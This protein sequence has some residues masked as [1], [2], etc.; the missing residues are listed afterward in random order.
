MSPVVTTPLVKTVPTGMLE[1]VI[2][3]LF[4]V[5]KMEAKFKRLVSKSGFNIAPKRN[6]LPRALF[7]LETN[8]PACAYELFIVLNAAFSLTLT[9]IKSSASTIKP[10]L[11][12]TPI[13]VF[14][15]IKVVLFP[16]PMLY[17]NGELFETVPLASVAPLLVIMKL[18]LVVVGV[19]MYKYWS[20]APMLLEQLN[21]GI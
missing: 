10:L 21:G 7:P 18:T 3:V 9:Y 19:E 14:G 5:A 8:P 13:L 15:V 17:T 4:S 16:C 2:L 1:I 11:V 20:A 12:T 6:V